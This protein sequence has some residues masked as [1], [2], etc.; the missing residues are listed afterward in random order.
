M[1]DDLSRRDYYRP[2]DTGT[3]TVQAVPGMR[4]GLMA[5]DK[6]VYYLKNKL[7]LSRGTVSMNV[8]VA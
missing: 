5:V 6:A 4:I 2:G 1:Q 3:L 7:S 8:K